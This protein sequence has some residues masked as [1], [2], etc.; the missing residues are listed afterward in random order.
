MHETEGREAFLGMKTTIAGT[1]LRM[2]VLGLLMC[3]RAGAAAETEAA[4]PGS[5]KAVAARNDQTALTRLKELRREI[6][7]H[8]ELYYRKAAPVI[9]DYEYDQLKAELRALEARAAERDES[10][11]GGAAAG[12]TLGD[13]RSAGF[14]TYRHREPM[15]SLTKAYSDEELAAFVARVE[16]K[17][18]RG[19]VAFR[20]EPKYDGLAVSLTY[21]KGC[22]VR[23]VTRGNGTDGDDITAN[24]RLALRG[25]VERLGAEPWSGPDVVELRGEIYMGM[26]EFKRLNTAREAAGEDLFAHPRN[27]AVGTIRSLDAAEVAERRLELVCY[28]WGAWLPAAGRPASL[29]EFRVKAAAWGLPV[30]GIEKVATGADE[31]SAAVAAVR[32]AAPGL[33]LPVDGVVIK[34]ERV[35]Q[36]EELG[37]AP[38][39]P[40]WA[41]ARKFEPERAVT[42]LLGITLQV[43]RTGVATPVAELAPVELAGS[44]IARATLHN[45][46]EIT[47]RDLRVGDWVMVEKAGEIIPAIVGV[48]KARRTGTEAPY[49][50]P[51]TCPSCPGKLVHAAGEAVHRCGSRDCPAQVAR[52]IAHFATPSALDIAGIGPAVVDALVARGL[53]RSPADLYRLRS[54]EWADLPGLGE[55][56]AAKLMAAL[57]ASRTAAQTDGARL[58]YALGLPGVGEG[59]A[60]RLAAVVPGLEA[61]AKVEEETLRRPTDA[62]GAGFGESAARELCEYLKRSDVR[63]EFLALSE[64]GIGVSWAKETP[65]ALADAGADVS[66]LRGQVVVL[67]GTLTRWTRAGATKL[68]VAHG[69]TVAADVTK[70][71]TLLIAG[72]EPGAKLAKARERGIEVIDEAELVRR[73]GSGGSPGV[74]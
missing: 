70:E 46:D 18:G 55:R 69:A 45:A 72:A 10:G 5:P 26:A 12:E 13:D 67:T 59:A 17:F 44:T 60:R 14:Q 66:P 33:G 49:V 38:G 8:D 40:R 4:A 57:A 29:G 47:R 54:D 39:A 53:A 41:V 43:G 32:A 21:E 31:L 51:D 15:L 63:A 56:S 30:V 37:L 16:A 6:A 2:A 71:T 7:R 28:G 3:C 11:G 22:L 64:A 24:A 52:R 25:L 20:V 35:A 68:L 42:R 36:Q 9:S 1:W 48:E 23:A 34:V 65:P 27:V 50:F 19:A 61:L 73:L 62:G 74:P 58:I